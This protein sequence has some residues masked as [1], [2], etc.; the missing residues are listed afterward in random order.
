V[1]SRPQGSGAFIDAGDCVR[2][3]RLLGPLLRQHGPSPEIDAARA[4]LAAIGAAA[5]AE[6]AAAA[7]RLAPA[8]SGWVTTD[9]AAAARGCSRRAIVKA[10]AAG[11]LPAQRQGRRWRVDETAL[12]D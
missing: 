10:I 6:R 3:A 11:R 2:L 1:T 4:A 5:E 8:P 7:A 9:E 12:A